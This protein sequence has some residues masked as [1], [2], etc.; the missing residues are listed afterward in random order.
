MSSSRISTA[1][2][3][4]QRNSYATRLIKMSIIK[5]GRI[6][7][8]RLMKET[9]KHTMKKRLSESQQKST[10]NR[11]NFMMTGARD[12]GPQMSKTAQMALDQLAR[13]KAAKEERELR[14]MVFITPT[15]Y[16]SHGKLTE[17]GKIY[18][19]SDGLVMK[20]DRYGR[21]KTM[22]GWTVGKYKANSLSNKYV[23][24]SAIEKHSPYFIQQRK[25][26]QLER[27]AQLAQMYGHAN[28]QAASLYGGGGGGLTE[29]QIRTARTG[30]FSGGVTSWGV[31]SDN[32]HG[33]FS[34]NVWGTIGDNVWGG[35][36]TNV[37]GGF[38]GNGSN[39]FSSFSRSDGG[40]G[41]VFG[42]K[43]GWKI[44][45]SNRDGQRNLISQ[46]MKFLTGRNFSSVRAAFN[47]SGG[48]R[49]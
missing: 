7:T 42:G 15:V 48:G 1:A 3:I 41:S 5:G 30:A 23:I 29:E 45:G 34:S 47:R 35:V 21:I 24:T 2:P 11:R 27:D 25:Q 44:F 19:V 43:R 6:S 46:L 32:A 40:G 13:K 36:E 10:D 38:G 16:P 37:W 12:K 39:I 14:R 9:F 33:T 4:T 17:K 28:P 18:D 20:V 26:Q 22:T 8:Q 31:M 49:R